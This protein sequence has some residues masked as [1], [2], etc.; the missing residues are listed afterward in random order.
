MVKNIFTYITVL[1]TMILPCSCIEE[2]SFDNSAEGNFDA[3][4]T[5]IDQRYCFLSYAEEEYGLDW[6]KMY[7][8]YRSKITDKTNS[9][10]L[11]NICGEL[12][13]ELR[14]GHVNLTSTYG[15]TFNWDWKLL[16]PINFSDSLQRNYLGTRF[17]LNNGIRYN[18]LEDSIAYAHVSTFEKNFGSGNLTALLYT[19]S[20]CKALILDLRNNGGGMLTAA[21]TLA[22]HFTAAKI[23]VGYMQHKTG[24]AHDAFSSP[25]EIYLSPADGAIWLRPVILLTNRGVFSAANH[26]VMMMRELPHVVV[27]GDKTGGGSGMP[28]SNTLPNGWNVRFSACPILDAEGNHTEFGIEPD[29]KVSITSEDWNKGRDTIIEEAI[30]LAKA[31]TNNKEE[32]K[33]LQ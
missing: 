21:E 31:L 26:F 28:L 32:Q 30:K 24:K 12:L 4:W 18:I 2:D 25:K 14:D 6:N 8:K 17:M 27:M 5:L 29:I 10:Q 23:K 16:Y 19:I 13:S 7:H 33:L 20:S 11:F 15:T 9:H 3:L 1:L 22:S